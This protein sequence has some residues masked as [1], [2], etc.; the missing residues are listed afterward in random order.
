MELFRIEHAAIGTEELIID[1]DL[2]IG[3]NAGEI[4]G[5]I[6]E[7]GSGKSSLL[8]SFIPLEEE[9][10][11]M[12]SGSLFWHGEDITAAS[13]EEKRLIFGKSIAFVFQS[14]SQA[15]DPI[16]KIR[17]QY[18][19]TMRC[20]DRSVTKEQMRKKASALLSEVNFEM[21]DVILDSYPFELSGGMLQRAALV[22]SML[23]DPELILADEMTSALD[24]VS[25]QQVIEALLKI[26]DTHR[27]SILFVTH[28]MTVIRKLADR[29]AVMYGGR[30]VETGR[31]EE[32]LACPKHPYTRA[33][34]DAVPKKEHRLP[35]G[36][37]G[38]PV[39]VGDL[40]ECCPYYTR[41][42]SANYLCRHEFPGKKSL[43]ETHEI[44][45]FKETDE[46]EER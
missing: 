39:Y 12:R 7:S 35:Q 4:V 19:E 25:Q 28:N 26:R 27:T 20:R 45:C 3:V 46:R 8:R 1:R 44:Y 14:L 31:K 32:I 23:N 9:P 6:G 17:D 36:I 38:I 16:T 22:M 10:V 30:I 37:P 24:L 5:I 34:I 11:R 29:V 21:P 2:A 43:S 42:G 13:E 33:L 40:E 18:L 41:C 15:F